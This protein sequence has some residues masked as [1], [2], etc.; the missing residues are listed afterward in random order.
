MFKIC[1]L[2]FQNAHPTHQVSDNTNEGIAVDVPDVT[3]RFTAR[4]LTG[5]EGEPAGNDTTW[6]ATQ[7]G[8]RRVEACLGGQDDGASGV[9]VGSKTDRSINENGDGGQRRIIN[10]QRF[11]KSGK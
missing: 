11:Y 9:D 3:T 6:S 8:P 1:A 10:I 7:V 5:V 4:F 2:P